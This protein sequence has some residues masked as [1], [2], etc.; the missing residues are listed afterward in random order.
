MASVSIGSKALKFKNKSSENN[1]VINE[2]RAGSVVQ[3]PTT[4][5]T[6]I[7]F[8]ESLTVHLPKDRF[9]FMDTVI[10]LRERDSEPTST[11]P[12]KTPIFFTRGRESDKFIVLPGRNP[13]EVDSEVNNL[14]NSGFQKLGSGAIIIFPSGR[15]IYVP[16]DM[17]SLQEIEV[18][19]PTS[20]IYGV[21]NA[22]YEERENHSSISS[23]IQTSD[24]STSSL[25]GSA[26]DIHHVQSAD[27]ETIS[28]KFVDIIDQLQDGLWIGMILGQTEEY[29]SKTKLKIP[30]QL[31]NEHFKLFEEDDDEPRIDHTSNSKFYEIDG[32]SEKSSIHMHELLLEIERMDASK[33]G[34]WKAP[35]GDAGLDT[36]ELD[37]LCL[38]FGF[39]RRMMFGG[40]TLNVTTKI[41]PKREKVEHTGW[42]YFGEGTIE[43]PITASCGF[44]MNMETVPEDKNGEKKNVGH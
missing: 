27:Y 35:S 33:V 16:D 7:T 38:M 19:Y 4:E 43:H 32:V 37:M 5:E 20:I 36:M 8:H 10:R 12:D 40:V 34:T 21:G 2:L 28:P 31:W 24:T 29:L 6:S 44:C 42:N 13:A 1:N 11:T 30:E 41:F 25:A 22:K 23:T 26:A 15:H 17:G 18:T 39:D 9:L 3:A 14:I